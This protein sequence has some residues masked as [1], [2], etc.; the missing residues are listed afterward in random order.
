MYKSLIALTFAFAGVVSAAPR[1]APQ[2]GVG[3]ILFS[4]GFGQT[5]L[6]CKGFDEEE[7]TGQ[8]CLFGEDWTASQV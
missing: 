2:G 1:P 4:C 6:C 7:N 8:D 5:P 3:G